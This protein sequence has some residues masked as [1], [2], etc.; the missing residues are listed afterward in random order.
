MFVGLSNG[1]IQTFVGFSSNSY[2]TQDGCDFCWLS[3]QRHRFE[4]PNGV[5]KPDEWKGKGAVF[6]CGLLLNPENVLSIFFTGNGILK[7]KS[8]L[9]SLF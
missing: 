5:I 4:W 8:P 1:N 6:G 9:C 7:G 2:A 3:E